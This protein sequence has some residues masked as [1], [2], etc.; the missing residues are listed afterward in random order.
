MSIVHINTHTHTYTCLKCLLKKEGRFELRDFKNIRLPK[1]PNVKNIA[2][3]H[4]EIRQ[5]F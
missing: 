1:M 4:F 3:A 5:K 2:T